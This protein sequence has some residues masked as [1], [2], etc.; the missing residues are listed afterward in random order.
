MTDVEELFAADLIGRRLLRV[1]P[2][3]QHY[4]EDEPSLLSLTELVGIGLP[5]GFMADNRLTSC[6]GVGGLR[7]AGAQREQRSATG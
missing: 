5:S 7:P 3:W 6:C 1:T 4:A 2:A